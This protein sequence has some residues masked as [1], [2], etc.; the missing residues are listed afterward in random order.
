M[1]LLRAERDFVSKVSAEE[2]R[3][4]RAELS[5]QQ[6]NALLP[7]PCT[8]AEVMSV[9]KAV[10]SESSVPNPRAVKFNLCPKIPLFALTVCMVLLMACL[11][12]SLGATIRQENERKST[13]A[14]CLLEIFKA[15]P[16]AGR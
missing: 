2:K 10:K 6:T 5:S 3:V 8:L 9:F 7:A 13:L 11:S 4:L 1:S 14:V 15:L 16:I 12:R